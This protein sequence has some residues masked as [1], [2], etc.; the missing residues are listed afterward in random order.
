MWKTLSTQRNDV[1]RIKVDEEV[2]IVITTHQRGGLIVRDI[3]TD[4]IL[5]ALP[6]VSVETSLVTSDEKSPHFST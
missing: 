6:K 1:H 4:E 2:G 3:D 5:W